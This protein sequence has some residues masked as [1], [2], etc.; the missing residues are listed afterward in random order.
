MKIKLSN[1]ELN[2]FVETDEKFRKLREEYQNSVLSIAK[3]RNIDISK[4]VDFKLNYDER[5]IEF[6]EAPNSP[7]SDNAQ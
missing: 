2:Y 6:V 3:S 7:V 1:P 4:I 5:E